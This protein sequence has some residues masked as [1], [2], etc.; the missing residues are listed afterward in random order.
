[1]R[2][3]DDAARRNVINAYSDGLT[4]IFHMATIVCEEAL[5]DLIE[6]TSDDWRWIGWASN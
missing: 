3:S 4:S 6:M 5:L 2:R 1:M